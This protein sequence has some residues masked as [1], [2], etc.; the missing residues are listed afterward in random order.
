M[1]AGL[2]TNWNN[3]RGRLFMFLLMLCPFFSHGQDSLANKPDDLFDLSLEELLE[4]SVV[5]L[6]RKLKLYGYINTNAEQQ[7]GFPSVANDG[8]TLKEDDPFAWVPVK[9]FHLYGSAYLSERIEVLFNLAYTDE[10]IEVR[11]AWGNFKLRSEFQVRVGKMYRRFGLYNEKLDQI[12]TFIGI[13]P[14][15]IFDTDHLFVTR[16][17]SLMLH[18][19]WTKRATTLSYALTT[20]NGEGGEKKGLVPLGWDLRLKNDKNSIIVGTSGFKSSITKEKTTST[21]AFG[22]GPPKGGVLPWMDGDNFFLTGIF[23]E[24]QIKRLNIQ[25]EYWNA[26]HDALRNPEAVLTM[27]DQAGINANQRARFLGAN[28]SKADNALT[29]DDVVVPVSYNVQTYYIRLGYNVETKIGQFVPYLFLD[30]MSHPEVINNK[31]FGGDK[32]SGLADDG[33][34]TKTSAGVVYRPIPT[35]AIKL[36]GSIHS[37]KFNGSNVS[38][39]EIRLDFSWAFKN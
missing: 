39:P 1:T 2:S 13:E 17:T 37:Q 35:V 3:L 4:I 25:F 9:A 28:A 26:K 21:V 36:D 24:K 6:D 27:I 22:D 18:G 16:T 29:E 19:N 38:Y 31:T 20:E 33:K 14:P 34:F 15:E 8:T 5:E 23:V 32:E 30:W 10:T 11:N 12:P 7:F